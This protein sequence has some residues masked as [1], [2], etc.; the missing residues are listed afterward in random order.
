MLSR[1]GPGGSVQAAGV[2]TTCS[3]NKPLTRRP[4]PS[5]RSLMSHLGL[6]SRSTARGCS[7]EAGQGQACQ[8]LSLC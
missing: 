7:G 4:S 6:G 2:G 8:S 5:W 3:K 1:D